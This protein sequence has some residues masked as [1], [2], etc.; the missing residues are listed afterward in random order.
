MKFQRKKRADA[1]SS[2]AGTTSVSG[3]NRFK[4]WLIRYG[5]IGVFLFFL[6]KGLIW[7]AVIGAAWLGFR[8]A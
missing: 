4:N 7:L 8:G 2:Q 1:E 6:I 5:P 3:P